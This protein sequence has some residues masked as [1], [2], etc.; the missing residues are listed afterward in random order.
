MAQ[1]AWKQLEE[2]ARQVGGQSLHAL[3]AADQ[4]RVRHC[5][6]EAA[7]LYLDYSKQRVTPEVMQT[8][9]SLAMQQGLDARRASLLGGEIVN[10][11]EQRAAWHSAL[12]APR[13]S[14]KAGHSCA[15]VHGVLDAMTE[16]VGEVRSGRWKGHDGRSIRDIVNI[17]IGGSGLGPRLVCS[18]LAVPQAV[19]RTHFVANVD[20]AEL[21]DVLARLDPATTLF[22]VVSKSF[23]TAETLANARAARRWL[24]ANGALETDVARHFV[25]VSTH[26]EAVDSFGIERMFEFWDWVGGRFSLWSA[27][28]LSIALALGMAAFEQLLAGAH[29]M[30]Q[31]FQHAPAQRNLP[32]T[33]ALV[34][35]W[36]RNFLGLSGHV[37]VPYAK[38]LQ[39][40]T[41]WL[42]QVEMES[43][44]KG[45]SR[46]G[47]TLDVATVP[48][49]WGTVGPNA[50][51]AYFQALHQATLM[52]DVDFILPLADK[53]AQ[54][55]EREQQRLAN[56]LGQA[57]ALM[58]GREP[59]AHEADNQ[60]QARLA[61]ARGFDGDRPSSML[62]LERLDAWHLGA[63]LAAYEHKVFVQGVIWD[64]NSFDQWGVELGK[65]LAGELMQ[66]LAEPGT[67]THDAS[68]QAL[69]ERICNNS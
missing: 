7:G 53:I 4:A 30:D 34:G 25:A 21:D 37:V 33:M 68:T 40:F 57:Q 51:H 31:H 65:E 46:A 32:L 9:R 52:A 16:F 64:I 67:S 41:E 19:P 69:L 17:G 1:P 26:G 14:V 36:N 20:P 42:Q 29:A 10:D 28:G 55:D 61:A 54:F 43:N 44:G 6:V 48:M 63:L 59:V 62:L 18:A 35:I 23:T 3:F 15:E 45:V 49:V 12:R 50:Q 39:H 24:L 38:R 13:S 66:E 8:L 2:Q 56:C 11:S 5:S 58:R 60:Q 47:T 22:V 27:A